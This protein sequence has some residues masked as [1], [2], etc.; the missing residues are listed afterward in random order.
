MALTYKVY[1]DG[2]FLKEVENL[3]T[4]VDGL[5]KDTEYTIQISETDGELESPL[6]EAVKFVTTII[7]VEEI[8]LN[9]TEETLLVT[10]SFQLSATIEPD[11]ATFKEITWSTSDALIATVSET[12]LIETVGVGTV[13][14]TAESVDG[15]KGTCQLTVNPAIIIPTTDTVVSAFGSVDPIGAELQGLDTGEIFGG[16]EPVEVIILNTK[17]LEENTLLEISSDWNT[18]GALAKKIKDKKFTAIT[19]NKSIEI[20]TE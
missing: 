7:P 16:T 12:G 17:V 3:N 2:N 20:T 14:I 19:E 9:T 15:I 1:L 5:T 4:I 8:V 11:N 13:K 18:G 6:S 10:E